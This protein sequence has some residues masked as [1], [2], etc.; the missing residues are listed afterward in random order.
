MPDPILLGRSL[1]EGVHGDI[2]GAVDA[3]PVRPD[4]VPVWCRWLDPFPVVAVASLL[5]RGIRPVVF[6]EPTGKD[7]DAI[8]DGVHDDY[9]ID[10]ALAADSLRSFERRVVVR[11]AHEQNAPWMPWNGRDDP[12][13]YVA[14]WRHVVRIV[15]RVTDR[16][17]F[18]WCPDVSH[19]KDIAP[20]WP[21][22]RFV[23]L[24]GLDGYAWGKE[25]T[26][27]SPA[28]IFGPALR[29]VRS[30]SDAPLWI[31]EFGVTDK[32]THA[33]RRA[34]LNS[35]VRWF[36]ENRVACAIYFDIDMTSAGH[37][38]WRLGSI[39]PRWEAMTKAIAP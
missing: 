28:R 7:L 11:F 39:A 37:P 20:T 33:E 19:V 32:A 2:I 8:A 10:F 5:E 26:L 36:R 35:A 16:I 25:S 34:W 13:A 9:L 38:D 3:L 6:W 31:A 27:R 15:R 18:L 24:V 22:A 12:P 21:G 29:A 23:D 4:A 30:L 14:A 17:R 1:I